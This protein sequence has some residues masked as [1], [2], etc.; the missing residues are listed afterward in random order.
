MFQ[1][2]IALIAHGPV[3]IEPQVLQPFKYRERSV[4]RLVLGLATAAVAYFGVLLTLVETY[5]LSQPKAAAVYG[6][7]FVLATLLGVLAGILIAPPRQSKIVIRGTCAFAITFP[8]GLNIYFGAIANWQPAFLLY[9]LGSIWGCYVVT[10]L[11][12]PTECSPRQCR[13]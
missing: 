6:I 11:S 9:L 4:F 12:A 7:G 2:V 10:W 5:P 8:V 1:I 3:V 13:I